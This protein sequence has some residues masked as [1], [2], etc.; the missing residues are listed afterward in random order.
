MLRGPE[1]GE[2]G[3][4]CQHRRVEEEDGTGRFRSGLVASGRFVPLRRR[5]EE[6]AALRLQEALMK[7]DNINKARVSK[8]FRTVPS[9]STNGTGS[10]G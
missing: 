5:R 7:L 3:G 2:G 6:E 4:V 8:V 1:R 10:T 9:R